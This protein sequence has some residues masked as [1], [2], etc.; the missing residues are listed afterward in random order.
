[1]SRLS[2]IAAQCV[3]RRVELVPWQSHKV[4]GARF[5]TVVRVTYRGMTVQLDSGARLQNLTGSDIERWI[6]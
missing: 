4:N 6:D 1:M 3:G 5:G 2:V